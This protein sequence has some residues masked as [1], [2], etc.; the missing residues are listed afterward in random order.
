MAKVSDSE[1]LEILSDNL[2]I[3][4]SIEV[5][6]VIMWKATNLMKLNFGKQAFRR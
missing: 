1:S 4:L 6:P 5:Y 3:S 2:F